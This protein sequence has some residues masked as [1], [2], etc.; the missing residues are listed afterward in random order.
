MFARSHSKTAPSL[1]SLSSIQS[2]NNRHVTYANFA[3]TCASHLRLC[4]D[5]A[6]HLAVLAL[7]VGDETGDPTVSRH[8]GF[9]ELNS[10]GTPI[11]VCLSYQSNGQKNRLITDPYWYLGDSGERQQRARRVLIR[12]LEQ[13]QAIDLLPA[14]EILLD[15]HCK[16]SSLKLNRGLFWL[17]MSHQQP[18]LALFADAAALDL[19]GWDGVEIWLS[20]TLPTMH[21]A[22]PAIAALRGIG[23]PAS[24]GFEAISPTQGRAKVYWRLTRPRPL[25]DIGIDL[26][27][28]PRISRFLVQVV[29]MRPIRTSSLV[30]CLGFDLANG[31]I[32]DVKVDI[33]GHCVPR[34]APEWQA[35]LQA[36]A[37]QIDLPTP[38]IPNALL[39][40]KADVAFLGIGLKYD[41]NVR[42]NLYLKP[43]APRVPKD[44]THKQIQRSLEGAADFLISAQDPSGQFTDYADLPVGHATDWPTAFAGFAL[45]TAAPHLGSQSVVEAASRAATDLETHR[46]YPVGWGYNHITGPDADTTGL[47]LR[48]LRALGRPVQQA[49]EDWLVSLWHPQGGF[50]TYSSED[51]WG[52]VHPCVTGVAWWGLSERAMAK[53]HDQLQAYLNYWQNETGLTPSYW[54]RT[55]LYSTYHNLR[56]RPA[57]TQP[58]PYVLP[59]Q[60]TAFDLVHAAGIDAYGQSGDQRALEN[61]LAL[62]RADGS[63][64]GG[65]N[66]RV[67]EPHC[68][69]PWERPEGQLYCD[70]NG[71]LTTAAALMVFAH[72][73]EQ[74][75]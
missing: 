1:S 14:C 46:A 23:H 18:G 33:C 43:P 9:S 19:A 36:L 48:L 28:D 27:H 63:W 64:P 66:L 65:F 25:E 72:M 17:G 16:T 58:V 10:D 38:L 68:A 61:L 22:G 51:H 70:Y 69:A 20:K 30:F 67:T 52:D 15:Q 55:S 45:A 24:L 49:D 50:S 71:I 40:P 8:G 34:S 39:G 57:P 56:L 37:P 7:G 73:K 54:W 11:Q 21:A 4:P 5:S 47:T 41:G 13:T 62:Q 2:Q 29:G 44:T 12:A 6:R 74:E 42:L 26:F 59:A 60:P 3:A 53:R 31:E 32:E 35:C 75:F